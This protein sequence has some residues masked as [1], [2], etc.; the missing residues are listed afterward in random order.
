MVRKRLLLD[1]RLFDGEG[2]SPAA[3]PSG[4]AAGDQGME[5]SAAG[6]Q[7]AKNPLAGVRYGV[8]EQEGDEADAAPEEQTEEASAEESGEETFDSLI[9]GRFKKDFDQR[10]QQVINRRFRAAKELEAQKAKMDPVMEV[11]AAKYQLDPSDADGI[12][13]A[14]QSDL[15]LYE[16]PAMEHGMTA[17]QYRE[18][19]N[20]RMENRMLRA[21]QE[22]AARQQRAD[23]ILNQWRTDCEGLK[24]LYPNIDFDEE[25]QNPAVM[26]LLSAGVDFK[27]AFE[28]A[29]MHEIMAG[30]LNYAVQKTRED[31]ARNIRNRQARPA[32]AGAGT[33]ASPAVK[34][35]V[36]KLTKEDRAEIVRRMKNG[37][38]ISF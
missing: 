21:R 32:E 22:E 28:S 5:V 3:A 12:L 7:R 38:H 4:E 34:R 33:K 24:G 11:L 29:H 23:R 13:K 6:R 19:S 18:L 35:D 17:E 8:Q 2:A 14:V 26:K 36:S 31:T 27:G 16:E 15:S 20:V 9:R 25:M 37:A 1:L 30:T 10:V